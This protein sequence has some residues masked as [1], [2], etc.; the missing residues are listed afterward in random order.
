MYAARG[1]HEKGGVEG[2]VE[3]CRRAVARLYSASGAHSVYESSPLQAA[4]RNINV[5]AQHASIDFD[6]SAEMYARLRLGLG[7]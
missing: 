5:G 4:F 3:L 1:A 2:E 7:K 6:S